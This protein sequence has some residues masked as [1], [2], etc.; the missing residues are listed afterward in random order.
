MCWST[1]PVPDSPLHN[2]LHG[3][4]HR[5]SCSTAAT[6]A[7]QE[8]CDR[9]YQRR[10][11]VSGVV[12]SACLLVLTPLPLASAMAADDSATLTQKKQASQADLKRL[13]NEI[14]AMQGELKTTAAQRSDTRNGLEKIERQ[15]NDTRQQT[16]KLEDERDD[17]KQQLVSLTK[18]R[19][20]LSRQQ[21]AQKAAVAE[22]M[23]A[24]YRLGRQPELKLLLNQD[25]PA[26]LERLQVYLN[27]L[28]TSRRQALEKL[29]QLNDSLEK[30]RSEL[31]TRQTRLTDVQKGLER[32]AKT[33]I[34]QQ[35]ERS[36]LL[37]TLDARYASHEA[38]IAELDQDR[39]H[40]NQ[41]I[42]T[43]GERLKSIKSAPPPKTRIT[44]AMGK[45]D[46][47]APGR[48]ITAYGGGEGVNRDGVLIQATQGTAVT[49]PHAGRVVF[50][51]WMRGYGN[52]LIIDHGDN[53]LTLYAHLASF[54]VGPGDSLSR[55]Q[56]LGSV[57]SSGGRDGPALY[58]EVRRAG[59]PVNPQRWLSSR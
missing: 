15:L 37:R 6:A 14:T 1:M 39:A 44:R 34:A 35:N 49:A 59:Q 10:S 36:A 31:I 11:R 46:W 45:M 5:L 26:R 56:Q 25:D 43:L 20:T 28:S 38:R 18:Q 3:T 27:H 13:K 16:G 50:A 24:L 19:D 47:P 57:G 4:S 48:V 41:M 33:L 7:E 54:S 21:T 2:T 23:A 42:Q 30:T 12:L 29:A 51:D 8:G 22:E 17:I 40:A 32:Q 55:G 58:F 53:V 9:Q 52:L